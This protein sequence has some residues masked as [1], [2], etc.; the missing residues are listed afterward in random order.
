MMMMMMM[1]LWLFCVSLVSDELW[2]F[3]RGGFMAETSLPVATM[4]CL[5]AAMSSVVF[6][7]GVLLPTFL[8]V[9][10]SDDAPVSLSS[11]A[12]YC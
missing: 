1:C 9:C 10:H 2:M 7:Q 6:H 3:L 4:M 8:S 5:F 11:E 12:V